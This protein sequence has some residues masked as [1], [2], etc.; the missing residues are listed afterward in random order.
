MPLHPNG[1]KLLMP[2]ETEADVQALFEKALSLSQTSSF[3]TRHR[4]QTD[5]AD[6]FYYIGAIYPQHFRPLQNEVVQLP[7]EQ[8]SFFDFPFATWLY[9]LQDAPD[10]CV[11]H[12]M[13][14]LS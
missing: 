7:G 13:Q 9:L 14:R 3:S 10:S 5:I 4:Y 8:L 11:E 6:H 1:G 2:V 12:I